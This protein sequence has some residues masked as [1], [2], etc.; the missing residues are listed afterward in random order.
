MINKAHN[1]SLIKQSQS[2]GISRN[3]YYYKPVG[4]SDYNLQLMQEIDKLH[5]RYPFMG[6]RSMTSQLKLLGYA[7]NR[8]RVAR[9]MRL[10]DIHAIYPKPRTT[11]KN[12]EHRVYPYLL[13]NRVIYQPNQVWASDITYI[14]M[15]KGFVYLCVI[16]DWY[17]RKVLSWRLS[18][19]LTADF[20]VDALE[21]AITK[22]GLPEI[23][24]T[25]QGKQFT[26]HDFI[27]V[28][29]N[30]D[31]QIS[32]DGKGAWVD[33]VFVERLWRSLK[34]EEVY[35]NA[36]EGMSEAKNGIGN[37][38]DFYNTRRV[39]Q[40]LKSTPDNVYYNLNQVKLVA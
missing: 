24:N 2:L 23:M 3:H 38:I 27:H 17:S 29:K 18:N 20:C 35:L 19:T 39:H 16:M 21:C 1:L 30:N 4:E 12:D 40:S 26:C 7:V 34:Y 37:W 28:L 8:K 33:N 31:I 13:R 11:Q 6:G 10:M 22:H 32:M 25:D 5:T 14:P 36:Y 15:N 9:L